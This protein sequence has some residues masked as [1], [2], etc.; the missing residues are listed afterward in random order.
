[1]PEQTQRVGC[2]KRT[3]HYISWCVSRTLHLATENTEDTE[4]EEKNGLTEQVLD[5]A[6]GV[7]DFGCSP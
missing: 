7:P 2:V 5:A 4:M 6:I 1:M 3:T